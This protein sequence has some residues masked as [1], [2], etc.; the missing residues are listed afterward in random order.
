MVYTGWFDCFTF[1]TNNTRM[2][3]AHHAIYW[4]RR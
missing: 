3:I 1:V 4:S 2:Y